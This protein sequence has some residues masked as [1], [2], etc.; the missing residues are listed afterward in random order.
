MWTVPV[1]GVNAS[2]K[3]AFMP[4]RARSGSRCP[5]DGSFWT[6]PTRF[7]RIGLQRILLRVG[8][9]LPK[10]LGRQRFGHRLPA[11]R[12]KLLHPTRVHLVIASLEL[13]VID[14]VVKERPFAIE[15]HFVVVV[16]GRLDHRGL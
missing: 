15:P 2:V 11:A 12:L 14:L 9:K 5:P 3:T 1:M 10:L 13:V 6:S 4:S 8:E 7:R 16:G